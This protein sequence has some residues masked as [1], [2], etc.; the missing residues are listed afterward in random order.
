MER[1]AFERKVNEIASIGNYTVTFHSMSFPRFAHLRKGDQHIRITSDERIDRFIVE[2][3]YPESEIVGEHIS[4][5]EDV[6]IT[7]T[8]TK[9]AEQMEREMLRRF[10]IPYLDQ[11][12]DAVKQILALREFERNR[13]ATADRLW[14]AIGGKISGGHRYMFPS[15]IGVYNIEVC[16]AESIKFDLAHMPLVKALK[17]V[18]FMKGL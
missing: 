4:G 9:T 16:S 7:M 8:E 12:G 18:E 15:D 3:Y 5:I 13:R 1:L 11:L 10:F 17:L 6:K 14:E 2:G